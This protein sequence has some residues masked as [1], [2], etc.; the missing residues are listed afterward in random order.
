MIVY[1]SAVII[2]PPSYAQP[3]F[4]QINQKPSTMTAKKPNHSLLC[5][6]IYKINAKTIRTPPAKKRFS[7][8]IRKTIY[9]KKVELSIN[10]GNKSKTFLLGLLPSWNQMN[11]QVGEEKKLRKLLWMAKLL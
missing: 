10:T 2:A 6:K 11:I 4:Q 5:S 9:E 7:S 3:N 1:R 8:K